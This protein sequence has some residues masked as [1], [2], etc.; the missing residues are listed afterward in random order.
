MYATTLANRGTRYKAT[1]LKRVVASDYSELVLENSPQIV[2]TL[3]IS[4]D[5]YAAYMEGMYRVCNTP[6][7]SGWDVF[8]DFQVTVAGKTGTRRAWRRHGDLRQRRFYLLR[9]L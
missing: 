6:E 3:K 1:F 5:A 4:D 7:G 8:N 2:S 9:P